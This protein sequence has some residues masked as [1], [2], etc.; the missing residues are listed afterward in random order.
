[1][2]DY[3]ERAQ[4]YH[5]AIRP[6]V[7]V[8]QD[9]WG[10]LNKYANVVA[11][12]AQFDQDRT[13]WDLFVVSSKVKPEIERQRPQNRPLQIETR[14]DEVAGRSNCEWLLARA[15]E[16]PIAIAVPTLRSTHPS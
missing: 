15:P 2:T 6:T 1:M 3:R 16:S 8:G 5:G 13:Q 10:Q 9:E 11:G 4:H 14:S 12:S 7:D